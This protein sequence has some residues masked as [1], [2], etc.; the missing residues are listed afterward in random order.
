MSQKKVLM[1][2]KN[3]VNENILKCV[4]WVDWGERGHM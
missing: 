1:E 3:T 4:G 2:G